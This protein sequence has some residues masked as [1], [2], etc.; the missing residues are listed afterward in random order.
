[1]KLVTAPNLADPDHIYQELIAL[2]DGRSEDESMRINARLILLLINHIGDPEAV[3]EAMSHAAIGAS[4]E[5]R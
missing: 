4:Q 1:M 3:I 2:H 5:I